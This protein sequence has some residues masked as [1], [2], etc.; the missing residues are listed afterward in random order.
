M[1]RIGVVTFSGLT[2]IFAIMLVTS[3][4]TAVPYVE[5]NSQLE[6]L[7]TH[8]WGE[9]R[10][11]VK[12]LLST[13]ENKDLLVN[14]NP[15]NM[16]LLQLLRVLLAWILLIPATILMMGVM[17]PFMIITFPLMAIMLL[18]M[19]FILPINFVAMVCFEVIFSDGGIGFIKAILKVLSDFWDALTPDN[20]YFQNFPIFGLGELHSDRF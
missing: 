7:K 4:G 13:V 19:L 6:N 17:I 11:K 15:G 3:A 20:S 18:L 16:T 2:S 8:H 12:S 1:K 9:F 14:E 5:S 10:D